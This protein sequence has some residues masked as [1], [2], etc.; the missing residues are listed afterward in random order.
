MSSIYGTWEE[1]VGSWIGSNKRNFLLIKY[2]DLTRNPIN[3][4]NKLASFINI[5]R[6]RKEI[7]SVSENQVLYICKILRRELEINGQYLKIL[8]EKI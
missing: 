8:K 6:D 3:E 4:I 2:E 1:N 5:H 7:K